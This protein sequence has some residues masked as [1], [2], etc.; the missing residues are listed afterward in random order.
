MLGPCKSLLKRLFLPGCVHRVVTYTF[1]LI[2]S[3]TNSLSLYLHFY[4]LCHEFSIRV[5]YTVRGNIIGCFYLILTPV[6]EVDV[7]ICLTVL[8][9]KRKLN[10]YL[11]L[12]VTRLGSGRDRGSSLG[13]TNS[14]P[15]CRLIIR[16]WFF[17]L[18]FY[19]VFQIKH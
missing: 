12:K 14:A 7:S 2:N 19:I 10:E 11:F 18:S 1:S 8:M 13:L 6:F 17:G 15:C 16:I 5:N 4:C 9:K 3:S